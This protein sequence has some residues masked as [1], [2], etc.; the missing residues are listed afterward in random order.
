M[1]IGFVGREA[2]ELHGLKYAL[3]QTYDLQKVGISEIP[4][5]IAYQKEH[6]FKPIFMIRSASEVVEVYEA[7]LNGLN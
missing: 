6:G 1:F 5:V 3:Q 4:E 7:L 2:A